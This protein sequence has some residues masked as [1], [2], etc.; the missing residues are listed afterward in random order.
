MILSRIARMTLFGV[1]SYKALIDVEE[2][3]SQSFDLYKVKVANFPRDK[4]SLLEILE[5]NERKRN[6]LVENW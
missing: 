1:K 2:N 5:K 3:I 6:D 4:S